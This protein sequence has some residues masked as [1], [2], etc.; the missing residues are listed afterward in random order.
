MD[1]SIF[2]QDAITVWIPLGEA[3]IKVRYLSTGERAKIRALL[4]TLAASGPELAV[5]RVDAETCV[6]AVEEW[7]GFEAD[8]IPWPCTPDNVRKLSRWP[9]FAE[10]VVRSSFDLERFRAEALNEAKKNSSITSDSAPTTP[11]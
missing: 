10:A 2:L 6:A 9:D 8:G 1:V 11:A 4:T 5:E 3:R 7:E